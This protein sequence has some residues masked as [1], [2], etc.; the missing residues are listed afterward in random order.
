M[1]N[2]PA[3]GMDSPVEERAR[4]ERS[5][6]AVEAVCLC[7]FIYNKFACTVSSTVTNKFT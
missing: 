4:E 2:A 6:K 5:T 3:R 1:E 7:F